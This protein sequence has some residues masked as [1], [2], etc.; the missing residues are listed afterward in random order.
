MT[1]IN[2]A[3]RQMR[4]RLGGS[5]LE[6]GGLS[7]P[8]FLGYLAQGADRNASILS[9]NYT[10]ARGELAA[11]LLLR[12]YDELERMKQRLAQLGVEVE[13]TSAEQQDTAVRARI[14]LRGA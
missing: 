7:F 13:I 11:D 10:E 9:L 1:R 8:D 5:A 4:Q 14:R 6:G 12:S 3:Q 2:N